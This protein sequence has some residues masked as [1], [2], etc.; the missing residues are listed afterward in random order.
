MGHRGE[1]MSM[2]QTTARRIAREHNAHGSIPLV[3][4]TR[5]A[6]RGQWAKAGEPWVVILWPNG[7]V[8]Y[9]DDPGEKLIDWSSS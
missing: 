7:G 2:D 5:S 3:A 4:T 1:T 6:M 9:E 8:M